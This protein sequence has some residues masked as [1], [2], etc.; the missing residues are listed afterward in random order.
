MILSS[1]LFAVCLLHLSVW[2]QAKAFPIR[3]IIIG[4]QNG[5]GCQLAAK[6]ISWDSIEKGFGEAFRSSPPV[7]IDSVLQP[8]KPSFSTSQPTLFRERHGWCPYSERVWLALEA[9]NVPYDTVRI[10]NTGGGR[11]SYFG[12]QTPQMKWPDG[13][14]QGESYDLVEALDTKYGNDQLKCGD[15]HV[16]DCVNQFR[17]IFPRARPSSRAAYLFQNNGEPLWK[18]TFE[19]TLQKTDALLSETKGSFFCGE[20]IT[21][22]DIAWAPFLERYRYQLPC[23]HDGLEPDDPTVYPHLA[24]WYD[25]FENQLPAYAARVKGD[26]SSWRKVLLMAGFGNSGLPPNLQTNIEARKIKEQALAESRVRQHLWEQYA[27]NRPYVASTPAAEA[28]L[29]MTRNRKRIVVDIIKQ[30]TPGLPTVEDELDALLKE[31]VNI[32][33]TTPAGED[34]STGDLENSD[35]VQK[36]AAFLDERMCVPRDMGEMSAACIKDLAYKLSQ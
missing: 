32:L 3:P 27:A 16:Q 6:S 29:V 31:L 17:T 26:A 2:Q 28:A 9:L 21:G 25:E 12:G 36:L 33:A 19:E 14:T 15:G 34:Y 30:K 22:A 23:L 11:P 10:D 5:Q 18:S 24:K 1:T 13:R 4:R 7:S 20:S 35:G 8:D